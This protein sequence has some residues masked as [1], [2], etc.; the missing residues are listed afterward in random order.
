[1]YFG[2]LDYFSQYITF[3]DAQCTMHQVLWCP[4]TEHRTSLQVYNIAVTQ[5][6]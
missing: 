3:G 2:Y 5:L 1:M 4:I 6:L